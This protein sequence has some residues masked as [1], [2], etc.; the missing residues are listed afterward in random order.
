MDEP[1]W[2]E[3]LD[4]LRNA[5]MDNLTLWDI[6]FIDYCHRQRPS[7]GWVPNDR[8]KARLNEIWNLVFGEFGKIVETLWEDDLL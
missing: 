1:L 8:Q 7:P 2:K 4:V 3:R 6:D 5:D